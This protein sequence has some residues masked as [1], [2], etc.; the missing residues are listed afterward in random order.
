ML[1]LYRTDRRGGKP[2]SVDE[3]PASAYFLALVGRDAFV[4]KVD[5]LA[6]FSAS[7]ALFRWF[8]SKNMK[9]ADFLVLLLRITK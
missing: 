5:F 7:H 2:G 8:W 9:I 3:P 6:V 4:F 1:W